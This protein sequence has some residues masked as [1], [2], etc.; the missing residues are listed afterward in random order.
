MGTI[1][2][3]AISKYLP[4]HPA[5]EFLTYKIKFGI[6]DIKVDLISLNLS[7]SIIF[8]LSLLMLIFGIIF[9]ILYRQL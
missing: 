2:D 7:L 4:P 9:V 6:E 3:W 1:I 5:S 8:K